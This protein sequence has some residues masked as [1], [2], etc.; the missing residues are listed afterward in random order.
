MA[1]ALKIKINISKKQKKPKGY[2]GFFSCGF[3]EENISKKTSD[4]L[5]TKKIIFDILTMYVVMK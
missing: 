2:F 3:F 1:I 5:L 4:Y